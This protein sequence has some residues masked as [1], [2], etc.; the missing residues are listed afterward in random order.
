MLLDALTPERIGESP[1]PSESWHD[2]KD[3]TELPKELFHKVE[4]IVD[5][6]SL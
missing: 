3:K 2:Y 6:V 4:S 5:L 1:E